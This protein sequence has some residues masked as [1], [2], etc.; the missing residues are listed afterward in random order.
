MQEYFFA[1]ICIAAIKL[2]C[3]T[4][5]NALYFFQQNIFRSQVLS[6]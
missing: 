5:F 1:I 2:C 6:N 3:V 4:H